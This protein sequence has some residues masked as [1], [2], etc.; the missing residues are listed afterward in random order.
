MSQK[1]VI[2][3]QNRPTTIERAFDLARSGKFLTVTSIRKQLKLEGYEE[4]SQFQGR[5]L[6]A[7][8]RLLILAQK[9]AGGAVRPSSVKVPRSA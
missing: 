8:L 2:E 7:Q 1:V 6:Y 4:K 9:K 3:M 5:V